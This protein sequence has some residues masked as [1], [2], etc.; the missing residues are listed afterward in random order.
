MDHIINYFSFIIHPFFCYATREDRRATLHSQGASRVAP[1]TTGVT[2]DRNVSDRVSAH[3]SYGPRS[4]VSL[5]S[6]DTNEGWGM[7]GLRV[8]RGMVWIVIYGAWK[9]LSFLVYHNGSFN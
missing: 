7:G 8:R 5:A 3:R 2:S 9:F 4:I 6:H 1:R